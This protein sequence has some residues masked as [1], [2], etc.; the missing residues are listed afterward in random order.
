MNDYTLYLVKRAYYKKQLLKRAYKCGSSCNKASSTENVSNPINEALNALRNK[1]KRI[2]KPTRIET[3]EPGSSGCT[4]QAAQANYNIDPITIYDMKTQEIADA[5]KYNDANK[6][7]LRDQ[8]AK[9]YAKRY[10]IMDAIG[11]GLGSAALGAG[12]GYLKGGATGAIL[13]SLGAGATGAAGG[14]TYGKRSGNK[15]GYEAGTLEGTKLDNE[16]Y[17][18]RKQKALQDFHKEQTGSLHPSDLQK[19]KAGVR[20][21]EAL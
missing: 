7:R 2:K 8:R 5:I 3:C 12:L 19:T 21:Y 10:A 6:L 17:A 4:K 9:E 16:D 14:Y 13:G 1:R 20:I 15:A 11:A 18:S